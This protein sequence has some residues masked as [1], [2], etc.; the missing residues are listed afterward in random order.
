MV[1]GRP[2]GHFPLDSQDDVKSAEGTERTAEKAG[3]PWMCSCEVGGGFLWSCTH[4]WQQKLPA[5]GLLKSTPK[6]W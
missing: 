5:H 3:V 2:D 6:G 4:T 1:R